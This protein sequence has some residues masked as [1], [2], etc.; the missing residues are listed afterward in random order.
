[1]CRDRKALSPTADDHIDMDV[2][3]R[4]V[5]KAPQPPCKGSFAFS[6]GADEGALSLRDAPVPHD[7]STEGRQP[8]QSAAAI[9]PL[10]IAV[11]PQAGNVAGAV[12]AGGA[13]PSL[14]DYEHLVLFLSRMDRF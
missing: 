12:C 6:L 5:A 1:M 14:L 10:K 13:V 2:E 11:V 7:P 8:A 9:L 4:L 3:T